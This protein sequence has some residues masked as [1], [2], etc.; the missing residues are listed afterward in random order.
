MVKNDV[1]EVYTIVAL[2]W[3]ADNMEIGS[4]W[5]LIQKQQKAKLCQVTFMKVDVGR[6]KK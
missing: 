2:K 1:P 3:I 5:K 6:P 4:T